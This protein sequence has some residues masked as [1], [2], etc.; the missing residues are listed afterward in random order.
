MG[1][2]GLDNAE[3]RVHE[4]DGDELFGSL[5]HVPVDRAHLLRIYLAAH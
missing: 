5:F 1:Q 2:H 4:L 3:G